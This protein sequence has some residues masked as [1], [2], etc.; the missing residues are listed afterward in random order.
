MSNR[1]KSILKFAVFT[2]VKWVSAFYVVPG[3]I[4]SGFPLNMQIGNR[5]YDITKPMVFDATEEE[6]LALNEILRVMDLHEL[7][8]FFLHH[9]AIHFDSYA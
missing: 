2:L 1:I 3:I 6:I 8:C 7:L 4:L 5:L 9:I